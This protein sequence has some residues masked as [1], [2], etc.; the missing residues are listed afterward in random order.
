MTD[1]ESLSRPLPTRLVANLLSLGSL[2]QHH[3]IAFSMAGRSEHGGDREG[4]RLTRSLPLARRALQLQDPELL[5]RAHTGPFLEHSERHFSWAILSK[6]IKSATYGGM[7]GIVTSTSLVASFAGGGLTSLRVITVIGI[8][9]L[10]GDAVSMALGDFVSERSEEEYVLN[11]YRSEAWEVDNY[12]AGEVEEMRQLYRQNGMTDDDADAV[13]Q[14]L[15]KYPKTVF[16]DSMM[17]MELGMVPPCDGSN[18]L[19]PD[20]DESLQREHQQ[21][22][23]DA[24]PWKKALVTFISFVLFGSVP[25]IVYLP[26]WAFLKSQLAFILTLPATVVGLFVLGVL[27]ARVAEQQ[28][29]HGGVEVVLVGGVATA[30]AFAAGFGMERA[31]PSSWS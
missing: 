1:I 14:I 6:Y 10:I 27:K 17:F 28:W 16:L 7:D 12:F 23:R 13:V 22:R 31:V 25:L 4:F 15:A 9:N 21:V 24:P 30:A 11:E 26:L 8:G 19:F 3:L 29:Y 20:S 18:P 2:L 5:R